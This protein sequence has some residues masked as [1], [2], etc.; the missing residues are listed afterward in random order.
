MNSVKEQIDDESREMKKE[1]VS[2]VGAENVDD[3]SPPMPYD[4]LEAQ[5]QLINPTLGV[6]DEYSSHSKKKMM[7]KD[8]E[9]NDENLLA[10]LVLI[11][12]RD[13]R[14][15]NLKRMWGEVSY[16]QEHIDFA[17]DLVSEKMVRSSVTALSRAA[18]VNEV[19]QS[20]GGWFR[21]M[22]NTFIKKSQTEI[23]EPKDKG[24]FGK[25]N[26]DKGMEM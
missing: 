26:N 6:P 13:W 22:L 1:M 18:T 7:V 17:S 3:F 21:G 10:N 9:G 4:K 20:D 24:L 16:V 14:L 2:E 23:R 5:A 15:G 12:K 8:E 11:Y 25:Q 19:S